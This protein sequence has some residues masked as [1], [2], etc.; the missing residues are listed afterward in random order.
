MSGFPDW[1]MPGARVVE[2]HLEAG[3]SVTVRT[4]TIERLTTRQ[5][6]LEE[7]AS[8]EARFTLKHFQSDP[9]GGEHA[10]YSYACRRA[11]GWSDQAAYLTHPDD[12]WNRTKL[13]EVETRWKMIRVNGA[14]KRFRDNPARATA[15]ALASE[16]QRF[17]D[18]LDAH[19]LDQ[20]DG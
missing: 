8:G 14:A 17:V 18:H 3:S 7:E 10:G 4:R 9:P 20:S 1:V 2:V 5:I 11:D 12:P 13:L 6:V 15:E 16:A 19:G